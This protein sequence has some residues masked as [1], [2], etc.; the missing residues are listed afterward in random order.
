MSQQIADGTNVGPGLVGSKSFSQMS[1]FSRRLG[2][3]RKTSLDCILAFSILA[4]RSK[5]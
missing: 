3:S 2:N 1:E 4:K 5:L